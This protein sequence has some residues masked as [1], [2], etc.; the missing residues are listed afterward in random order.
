MLWHLQFL[1]FFSVI[2]LFPVP[3]NKI[4]FMWVYALLLLSLSHTTT[5][6]HTHTTTLFSSHTPYFIST[7]LYFSPLIF[8]PFLPY[9]YLVYSSAPIDSNTFQN[10]VMIFF[11][12]NSSA[13]NAMR[14][15]C[16]EGTE[17]GDRKRRCGKG[18]KRREG[19]EDQY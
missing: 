17:S 8:S 13:E 3:R 6:T 5:H 15:G 9:I 10:H 19:R 18:G 11:H 2:F 7:L 1:N 16:A 4:L 14:W 12:L